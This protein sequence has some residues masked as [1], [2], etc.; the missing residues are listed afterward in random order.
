M[1]LTAGADVH[2]LDDFALRGA[3]YGDFVETVQVL[4]AA[5]ANVHADDDYAS[6]YTVYRGR[7]NMMKILTRHIFAP[8]SWRGKSRVEIERLAD[9]LYDKIKD[10]N[11]WGTPQLEDVQMAGHILIDCASDCWKKVRPEPPRLNISPLPAQ[12]KPL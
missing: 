10:A 6:R 9:T 5:G 11:L 3:A 12:P 4:L 2:A 1:L 7:T 8:K